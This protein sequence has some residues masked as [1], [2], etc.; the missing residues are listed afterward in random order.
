MNP[1]T[2]RL[3]FV[4]SPLSWI[5][6]FAVLALTSCKPEGFI[7][8][9]KYRGET[10]VN[11]CESFTADVNKLIAANS[12]AT[13]LSISEYDNTDFTYFYLEPGQFE[14]KGDTLYARLANDL[15]YGQYLDKGVAVEVT[16]SYAASP[17]L[18]SMESDAAGDLG[19]LKVDR[20]Y[21]IAN[22]RPFFLYKFPLGGS[23][24]AGKQLML[25][26]AVAKYKKNGDLKNY[27]CE[28]DAT[29]IGT[30][31]PS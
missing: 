3:S 20:E 14:V 27:F 28:T 29:P 1:S 9:V 6:V 21:Y 18:A 16:A 4:Q 11:T 13:T 30:A 25:S 24:I 19:T 5:A 8:K 7:N 17:S 10:Y 31:T 2:V 26:F 23:S 15:E 22:R 12:N